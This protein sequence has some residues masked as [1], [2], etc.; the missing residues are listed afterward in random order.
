MLGSTSPTVVLNSLESVR[1][2]WLK[3][4][5]DYAG[6]PDFYSCKSTPAKA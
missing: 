3:K 2:A 4:A 1:E 6:R 5:N